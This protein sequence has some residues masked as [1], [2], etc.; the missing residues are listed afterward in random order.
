MWKKIKSAFMVFVCIIFFGAFYIVFN[1]GLMG[2]LNSIAAS[3]FLY[4]LFAIAI[5]VLYLLG[6]LTNKR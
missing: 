2:I 5:G 3:I 1:G 6:K 4:L